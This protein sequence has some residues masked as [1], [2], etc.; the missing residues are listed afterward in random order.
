MRAR[1]PTLHCDGDDGECYAWDLD[2][3][4]TGASSVDGVQL[5]QGQRTPGWVSTPTSDLCPDHAKEHV[6]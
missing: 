4:E 6:E 5:S 3:Y 1:V 2:Y